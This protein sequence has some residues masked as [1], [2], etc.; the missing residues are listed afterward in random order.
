MCTLTYIP[1]KIGIIITSNRDEHFSRG[2]SVFPVNVKR[3]GLS[4]FFPQDP[5]A[6]GSWIAADENR[7][8]TVLLNG[9]FKKHKHSPPYRMSRGI[10]LLDSFEYL[11][12]LHFSQ[13]YSLDQIEPFTMV[14][15]Q[16]SENKISEM[17]WDGQKAS[18][19]NMDPTT[20]HIWSS[21]SLYSTEVR[22]ERRHWFSEWIQNPP[23][24]PELMLE[25]H[26]F[27]GKDNVRNGITMHR[28]NGVQ[29]VSITQLHG[30]SDH[31]DFT[32]YNLMQNETH[33]MKI[34]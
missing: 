26:K 20:P 27:G 17:R 29:T 19:Q 4:I 10:V 24:T 1:N 15:F 22:W 9:A 31:L 32:H 2:N 14:Q 30:N 5:Q 34:S 7:R 23:L 8:I 3:D 33:H 12:L 11:D 13:E 25:F 18:H 28:S 21:T 16:I 6:G